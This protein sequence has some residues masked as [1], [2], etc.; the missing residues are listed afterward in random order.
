MDT[1]IDIDLKTLEQVKDY[2]ASRESRHPSLQ[3][4][5]SA[6]FFTCKLTDNVVPC[7][8]M[9]NR[10]KCVISYVLS[11]V[12]P[13][14]AQDGRKMYGC[15]QKEMTPYEAIDALRNGF[16]TEAEKA[17]AEAERLER[18]AKEKAEEAAQ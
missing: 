3:I 7:N 9:G 14:L 8:D 15:I 6:I 2:I 12:W 1:T 13:V 16:F 5:D 11:Y 18:Y 17:E 10:P 4:E